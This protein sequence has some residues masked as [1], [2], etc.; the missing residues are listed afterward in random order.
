MDR[1]DEIYISHEAFR[2]IAH[3]P[4]LASTTFLEYDPDLSARVVYDNGKYVQVPSL[5][6]RR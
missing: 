1:V 5:H 6:L 2:A 4:G 3:S